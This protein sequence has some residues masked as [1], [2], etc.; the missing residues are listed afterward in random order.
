MVQALSGG[1]ASRAPLRLIPGGHACDDDRAARVPRPPAVAPALATER[2]AGVPAYD[3]GTG[4][5]RHL[6]VA[7]ALRGSLLGDVTEL[8]VACLLPQARVL[9]LTAEGIDLRRGR[10]TAWWEIAG[11]QPPVVATPPRGT[12][13]RRVRLDPIACDRLRARCALARSRPATVAPDGTAVHL[14]FALDDGTP[15]S[16]GV[17]ADAW[18]RFI[19]RKTRALRLPPRLRFRDLADEYARFLITEE[20]RAHTR[21]Q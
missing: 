5:R 1:E 15:L 8:A 17:I 19:R 20:Q 13:G 9:A 18:R 2:L 7:Q 16:A 6:L 11:G 12:V 3:R 21:T 14:L 10:L 4:R